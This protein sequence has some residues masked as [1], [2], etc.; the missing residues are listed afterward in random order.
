VPRYLSRPIVIAAY[1]PRWPRRFEEERARLL[2]LL[3]ADV[4]ALEHFG[5]TAPRPGPGRWP[6]GTSSGAT[7]PTPAATRPSSG[8]PRPPTGPI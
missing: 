8:P 6:S 3:G 2:A 7:R 5:S 1:D 4:V